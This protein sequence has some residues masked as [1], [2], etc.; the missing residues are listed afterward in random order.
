M[1]QDEITESP[2]HAPGSGHRRRT[3]VVP[4]VESSLLE[5]ELQDS[6]AQLQ[7]LTS[8]TSH[9]KRKWDVSIPN[10]IRSRRSRSRSQSRISN[11]SVNSEVADELSVLLNTAGDV[12][13][14]SPEQ[15]K[16]G[17]RRRS[18]I[19]RESIVTEADSSRGFAEE[20]PDVEAAA[21]LQ[22]NKGRGK[23]AAQASPNGDEPFERSEQPAGVQMKKGRGRR[24]AEASPDLD[25]P[26]ERSRQMPKSSRPNGQSPA[27]SPAQ[28]RQ[29]KKAAL[30]AVKKPSKKA[31]KQVRSGSPI[32]VTV[33]RLTKAPV[34]DDDESDADILN[35]ENP[36][37]K[38]G[39]AN[40]IDVL[41]Q[42]C[43]EVID[44]SLD[45]IQEHR[46]SA[47]D[48]AAKREFRDKHRYVQAFGRELETRLL[49]HVSWILTLLSHG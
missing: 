43:K 14:L 16:R 30:K 23:R 49:E 10:T 21:I 37:A 28:Q 29:P 13:E 18:S 3:L 36:Y 27:S 15:P 26:S 42:V 20:I 5:D 31:K 19:Q 4:T 35:T 47:Q 32:P 24:R 38:R 39:S 12:D 33:H 6:T 22:R 34:Y 8:P 46:S 48:N 2:L 1:L 44:S 7:I 41:A 45:T 25:E 11:I 40:A 9:R 17:R